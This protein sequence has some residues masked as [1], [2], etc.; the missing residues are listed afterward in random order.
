MAYSLPSVQKSEEKLGGG[1]RIDDSK[2]EKKKRNPNHAGTCLPYLL[3]E[4]L[5]KRVDFFTFLR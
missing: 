4:I 1:E 3:V 5:T 2:V